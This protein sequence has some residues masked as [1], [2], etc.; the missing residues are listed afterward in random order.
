MEI[1]KKCAIKCHSRTEFKTK[2]PGLYETARTEKLLD[3]V[4]SHIPSNKTYTLESLSTDALKYKT[5]YEWYK[6]DKNSYNA[7]C[8]A[9]IIDKICNHMEVKQRNHT[10]ESLSN[11]AKKYNTRYE[12]LS[13]DPGSYSAAR[14]RGILNLVCSHMKPVKQERRH[15]NNSLEKIAKQYKSRSEFQ[16]RDGSAYTTARCKGILNE[17]CSHMPSLSFSIPQILCKQIFDSI[18]GYD[19]LYNSRKIIPPFELDIFYP[20]INFAIEYCGKRWHA[21]KECIARDIKKRIS[22]N[23][24]GIALL[25]INENSRKY[26]KDIKEQISRNL[27]FINSITN[28]H[29]T[30]NDIDKIQINYD[31]VFNLYNIE[32]IKS[33]VFECVSISEFQKKYSHFY[34]ILATIKRL[35]ILEPIR[36]RHCAKR[37][38]ICLKKQHLHETD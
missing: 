16:M 4:C 33:K 8:R 15:T 17:I 3:I 7:A 19:G 27:P 31:N 12:Y 21:T 2:F 5:R 29:L 34:R 10:I 23:A 37:G 24:S 14:R 38:K 18:T 25:C 13:K 32:D 9:K 35:D 28:S 22:C 1:I 26:E 30:M 36:I 11:D 6:Q 20:E